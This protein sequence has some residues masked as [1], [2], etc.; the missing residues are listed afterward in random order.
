MLAYYD[1][2]QFDQQQGQGRIYN[3]HL[4]V[5]SLDV[6]YFLDSDLQRL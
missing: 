4:H 6:L 3:E 1:S 5:V 2:K